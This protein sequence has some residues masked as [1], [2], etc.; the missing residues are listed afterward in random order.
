ME[1]PFWFAFWWVR[2]RFF[3][4]F[5]SERLRES[6]K[7]IPHFIL[8]GPSFWLMRQHYRYGKSWP[9]FHRI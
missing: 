9:S 6:I 7:I 5:Q 1:N 2:G 8:P 3:D 4:S